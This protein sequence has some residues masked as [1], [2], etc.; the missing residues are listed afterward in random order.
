MRY[1]EDMYSVQAEDADHLPHDGPQIF[2][3]KEDAWEI[4]TEIYA[5]RA[6]PG[7]PLLRELALPGHGS[8]VRPALPFSPL[9]KENMASLLVARQ[10]GDNYGKLLLIDFP[11][12]KLV[13]GPGPSGGPDHQR[14]GDLGP[15]NALGT[16]PA[17]R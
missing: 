16:K 5:L 4:P 9:S 3:N 8:G 10:D 11:K 13:F 12:D 17:A 7:R 14:S 15:D 2:Y 1:P 6:D